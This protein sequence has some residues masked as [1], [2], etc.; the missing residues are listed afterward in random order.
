MTFPPSYWGD[1]APNAYLQALTPY[2]TVWNNSPQSG[3]YVRGEEEGSSEEDVNDATTHG[4]RK[5][6][7]RNTKRK[8]KKVIRWGG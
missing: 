4:K 7:V 6:D 8:Y 2:S 1:P 3:G 5:D